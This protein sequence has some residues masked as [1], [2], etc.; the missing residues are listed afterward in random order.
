MRNN[1]EECKQLGEI[2]AED[3]NA[4]D[5]PVTVLIPQKGISVADGPFH[6]PE[7]DEAL[8]S[9]I[10]GGLRDDIEFRSL[11]LQINDPSFAK[12]CA[13]AL[14]ENLRLHSTHQQEAAGTDS[15]QK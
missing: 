2:L 11:D 4:Y 6:D 15:C 12:L 7:A 5:A 14:L 8:F 9:A 10:E 13:E 1:P 3:V